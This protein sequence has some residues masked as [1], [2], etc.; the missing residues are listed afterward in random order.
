MMPVTVYDAGVTNSPT[1]LTLPEGGSGSY[2]IVLDGPSG[3]LALTTALGGNQDEHVTVTVD[4]V[5]YLFTRANWNVPQTVNVT[6][7]TDGGVC[8]GDRDV[9]IS[10]TVTSDISLNRYMDSGYGGPSSPAS[11]V[12]APDEII[13]VTDPDCSTTGQTHQVEPPP[14][15][16]GAAPQAAPPNGAAPGSNSGDLPPSVDAAGGQ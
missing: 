10:E 1:S 4:G 9:S 16:N 15:L 5:D 14:A 11:N 7:P 3:F 6:A 13:H 2:T 12:D 8:T